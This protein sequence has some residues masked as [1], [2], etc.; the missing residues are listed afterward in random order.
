[1][2]NVFKLNAFAAAH[3]EFCEWIQVGIDLYVLPYV[4]KYFLFVPTEYLTGS[5]ELPEPYWLS[6]P[7]I[8]CPP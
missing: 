2:E 1:M 4:Y 7:S 3:T 8:I 5:G 6:L